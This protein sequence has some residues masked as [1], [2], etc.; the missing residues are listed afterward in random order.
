[1]RVISMYDEGLRGNKAVANIEI[2]HQTIDSIVLFDKESWSDA[3]VQLMKSTVGCTCAMAIM[4]KAVAVVQH[5]KIEIDAVI[6][7]LMQ[8]CRLSAVANAE[9]KNMV[10]FRY[11]LADYLIHSLRMIIQGGKMRTEQQGGDVMQYIVPFVERLLGGMLEECGLM[12]FVVFFR[13]TGWVSTWKVE[14]KLLGEQVDDV[15]QK[16]NNSLL[17]ER[18]KQGIAK[19]KDMFRDRE[20]AAIVLIRIVARMVMI[21]QWGV[22]RLFQKLY[23][24][25]GEVLCLGTMLQAYNVLKQGDQVN[26][27]VSGLNER[28]LRLVKSGIEF[29]SDGLI[30]KF[31]ETEQGLSGEV[32]AVMR[33]KLGGGFDAGKGKRKL[34][35][36]GK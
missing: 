11:H 31:V 14:P 18:W 19:E 23:G 2:R 28:A 6:E 32:L 20:G 21:H 4:A 12:V 1:M 33:K 34:F 5:G 30:R 35:E 29:A 13:L 7:R 22:K 15:L 10:M 27:E 26:R 9:D 16:T 8:L 3:V 36:N 25:V 17:F 24:D